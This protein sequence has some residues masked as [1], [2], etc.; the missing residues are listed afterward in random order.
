M[1]ENIVF[2]SEGGHNLY[3][4]ALSVDEQSC[5]TG[6]ISVCASFPLERVIFSIKKRAYRV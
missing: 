1:K 3:V 5:W 6:G 2:Q 4:N